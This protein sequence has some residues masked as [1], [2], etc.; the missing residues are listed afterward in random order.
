MW[1]V[2]CRM[3]FSSVFT[4]RSRTSSAWKF[5]LASA[6]SRMASSSVPSTDVQRSSRHD[7]S[8]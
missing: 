2:P 3:L 7:L 6:T 5:C 8:R 4:A 1:V